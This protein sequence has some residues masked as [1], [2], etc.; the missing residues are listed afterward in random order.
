MGLTMP[1]AQ[2]AWEPDW[3]LFSRL[4]EALRDDAR[5][6][7]RRLTIQDTTPA[8]DAEPP[9]APLADM[10]PSD[11]RSEAAASRIQATV[12]QHLARIPPTWGAPSSFNRPDDPTAVRKVDDKYL[13]RVKR[14]GLYTFIT[15]E[16]LTAAERRRCRQMLRELNLPSL[17]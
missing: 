5:H 13:F 2:V 7:I 17:D 4:P 16:E 6:L 1:E 14:D 12:R 11:A 3:M 8:V 9:T 10:L 15:G